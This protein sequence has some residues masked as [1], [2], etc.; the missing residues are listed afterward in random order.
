MSDKSEQ[1]LLDGKCYICRRREYC[2]NGCKAYK[3]R[4]KYEM[5]RVVASAMVRN[6]T[7]DGVTK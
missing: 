5:K 3:S 2:S 6:M 4:M 7:K 1:W